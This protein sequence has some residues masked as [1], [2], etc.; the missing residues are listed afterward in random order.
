M[1]PFIPSLKFMHRH[2]R[3]KQVFE[4]SSLW[5]WDN[6]LS[7]RSLLWSCS[8]PPFQPN[9]RRQLTVTTLSPSLWIMMLWKSAVVFNSLRSQALLTQYLTRFCLSFSVL[10][11]CTWSMTS[12]ENTLSRKFS[13]LPLFA[14]PLYLSPLPD[15]FLTVL[16]I[17]S[18]KEHQRRSGRP[19]LLIS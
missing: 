18:K 15:R 16:S 7:S 10:I 9:A 4:L 3:S 8:P 17:L 5:K 12:R 1:S 14:L 13:F 2:K 6:L 19:C 11:I